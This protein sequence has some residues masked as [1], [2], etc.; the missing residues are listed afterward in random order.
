MNN[1]HHVRKAALRRQHAD[2]EYEEELDAE[3]E[4]EE[5]E[6]EGVDTFLPERRRRVAGNFQKD[7]VFEQGLLFAYHNSMNSAI[8]VNHA[9]F[10]NSFEGTATIIGRHHRT[11]QT[12][13]RKYLAIQTSLIFIEP[14]N[15][16]VSVVISNVRAVSE[17]IFYVDIPQ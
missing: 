11:L 3:A 5:N 14:V 10:S 15:I 1:R 8:K 7:S 9:T 13:S 6:S 12:V 16:S 2:A 17:V 4:E